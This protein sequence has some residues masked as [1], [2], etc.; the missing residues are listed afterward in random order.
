MLYLVTQQD[1]IDRLGVGDVPATLPVISS[2]L[3]AAHLRVQSELDT[4]FT[5][6]SNV[7]V[8]YLDERLHNGV[9]PGGFFRL[10]LRNGFVR[11]APAVVVECGLS[12]EGIL[13][14]DIET[15]IG[16]QMDPDDVLTG[17]VKVPAEYR[18]KYVR[19]KYDSGFLADG[20]NVDA[21]EVVPD[22]LVEAITA[23]CPVVAEF[24]STTAA[25]GK[26]PNDGY[27][28]AADHAIAILT[29]LLRKKNFAHLP[30]Y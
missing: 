20:E 13:A 22:E 18:N 7:D 25:G 24:S 4:K 9:T 30:V 21:A 1:V 16:W 5:K 14:G 10:R 12:P 23:Y 26:N 11:S 6:K 19:V 29:P 3:K 8:F 2:A 15:V 27:K 17:Y 28:A